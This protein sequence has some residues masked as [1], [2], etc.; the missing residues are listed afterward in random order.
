MAL[1]GIIVMI[2][3]LA[4]IIGSLLGGI[5]VWGVAGGIIILLIGYWLYKRDNLRV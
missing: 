3:G 4:A 1:L 2:I 5:S